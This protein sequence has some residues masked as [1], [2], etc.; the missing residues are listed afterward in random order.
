[1]T[2]ETIYAAVWDKVYAI[3]GFVTKSRRTMQW[4]QIPQNQQPAI[5]MQERG[6]FP[7]RSG[8]HKIWTL[9]VLFRIFW[10]VGG[11]RDVPAIRLNELLDA[12]HEAFAPDDPKKEHCTL[13]GIVYDCAVSGETKIDDGS[14]DSQSAAYVPYEIIVPE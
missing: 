7:Q 2:R 9:K 11:D 8:K 4:D 13:G 12:L 1:M 5:F 3:P 10:R 6:E 14:F